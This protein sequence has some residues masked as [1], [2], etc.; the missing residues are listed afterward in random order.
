MVQPC[1]LTGFLNFPLSIM[2]LYQ[3]RLK[4]LQSSTRKNKLSLHMSKYVTG[5]NTDSFLVPQV[6]KHRGFKCLLGRKL[7]QKDI[8][9]QYFFFICT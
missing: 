9:A 3:D 8:K 4:M 1:F 2:Y 5:N 6:P 7:R